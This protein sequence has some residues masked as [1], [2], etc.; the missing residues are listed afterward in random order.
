MPRVSVIIPTYNRANLIGEAIKSVFDQTYCDWELIVVDDGSKDETAEVVAQ[1]GKRVTYIYQDNA[2]VCAARNLGFAASQGEYI[3]FLDSDDRMLPHNL[4]TLIDLLDTQPQADIA[5]GRYYWTDEQG[6]SP[7]LEG[8]T[9]EGQI[10]PQLV[11]EETMLLGITLIRRSCVE[12]IGGFD[13]AIQFQEHWD[14]YLRLAQAGCSYTCAKQAVALLRLHPKNR[15]QNKDAMLASRLTILNR[16]FNTPALEM[17][18][19][20][21]IRHQAY[22]NAYLEFA[23]DYFTL[24][25]FEQGFQCLNNALQYAP[26]HSD[27]LIKIAEKIIPYAFAPE[28]EDPIKF[29]DNLLE[30]LPSTRQVTQLH[31]KML[32]NVNAGLAFRY[33]RAGKLNHVW[34]HAVKAILQ[35]PSLS[36]NRGLL[37]IAFEGLAGPSVVDKF[38]SWQQHSRSKKLLRT[39]AQT[40]CIFISPHFDDAVL[41]CGGILTQLARLGADVTLVTVF[42]AEPIN[43]VPLSPLAQQLHKQWGERTN[44]YAIRH[45]EE[46]A[47][48]E[49]LDIKTRWLDFY[50]AIYRDSTLVNT[51]EL[52]LV[53]FDTKSDPCYEPVRDALLQLINVHPGAVVFAPLGLGH[54]RDH[55]VVYQAIESVKATTSAVSSYYYYE[56]YPY[57]AT[58]NLKA[59]LAELNWKAEP[60]VIDIKETVEERVRLI[61]MYQSQLSILFENPDCVYDEVIAYATRVGT[62]DKPRERFWSART[63]GRQNGAKFP[64]EGR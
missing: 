45:Q 58:A 8:P 23:H 10:L 54:H 30:A 38:R 46:R 34:R 4:K 63:G 32:G 7:T 20:E 5:Y 13:E 53:E 61:N 14:F 1:F 27:N 52:C 62:K 33:Y 2:G 9:Y 35:D 39:A 51:S 47:V 12:A 11:L 57:A 19:S 26:L 60:L 15:G 36:S 37:R 24:G 42:S 59:R 3:S 50:D 64:G 31:R 21:N 18:L 55:L 44:P 29:T 48:A 40:T 22:H 49:Y 56:D 28:I 6:Q 16:L 17:I 25:D 43:K 41:S